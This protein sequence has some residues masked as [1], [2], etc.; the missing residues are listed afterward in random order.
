MNER[1]IQDRL[2]TSI[3]ME[4]DIKIQELEM[5]IEG[6]RYTKSYLLKKSMNHRYGRANVNE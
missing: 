5:E 2:L 6:L 1:D 4:I 3:M